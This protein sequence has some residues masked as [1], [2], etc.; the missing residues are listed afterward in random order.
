M[1]VTG[2]TGRTIA[3]TMINARIKLPTDVVLLRT[4][5]GGKLAGISR[6]ELYRRLRSGTFPVPLRLGVRRVVWRLSDVQRWMA[7]RDRPS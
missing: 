7:E 4:G 5:R 1:R 2:A 6:S 3:G